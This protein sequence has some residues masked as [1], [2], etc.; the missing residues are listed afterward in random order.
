VKNKSVLLLAAGLCL[1][2]ANTWA[3]SY[4]GYLDT[5]GCGIIG[6]WAWDATQPNTPISVDIYDGANKI[7]TVPANNFRSDLYTYGY[8][9]GYHGFTVPT[10][11]ILKDNNLHYIYVKSRLYQRLKRFYGRR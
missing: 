4:A 3:Q 9:N 1:I 6:G 2:P 10:P 8:G 7:L 5:A 11:T